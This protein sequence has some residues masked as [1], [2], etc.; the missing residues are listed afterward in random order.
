MSVIVVFVM[1][2]GDRVDDRELRAASAARH[3]AKTLSFAIHR[4]HGDNSLMEN[5][6]SAN[7]FRPGTMVVTTLANPREKFWGA[8]LSLSPEGLSL[9]GIELASFEDLVAM[10]KDGEPFSL[11]VVFFP[12]HRVERMEL[13]L[14]DGNIPSLSQR[15]T[16]K[17]GLDPATLLRAESRRVVGEERA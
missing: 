13:D 3:W 16:A 6:P 17:T 7:P 12:M 2:V 4:K 10:V 5:A 11:G 8:I 9:R 14:P 15:F 1:A